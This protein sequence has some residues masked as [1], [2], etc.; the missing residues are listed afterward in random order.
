[1]VRSLAEAGKTNSGW[2]ILSEFRCAHYPHNKQ[3]TLGKAT[4]KTCAALRIPAHT[5]H[6][7]S[8]WMFPLHYPWSHIT[9]NE[10]RHEPA[11][12][13]CANSS[14]SHLFGNSSY[15]S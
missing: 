15:L 13:S 10:V 9:P 7:Y 5:S 1:L 14:S 4:W 12:E 8:P 6:R 11:L 3:F 2:L